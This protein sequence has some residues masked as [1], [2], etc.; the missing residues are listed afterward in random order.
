M[1][2]LS[3]AIFTNKLFNN[4]HE[5]HCSNDIINELNEMTQDIKY[6]E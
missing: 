2:R 3:L 6:N 5:D 1:N 4:W